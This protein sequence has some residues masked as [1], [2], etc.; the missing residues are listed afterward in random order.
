MAKAS[1][2]RRAS[3]L[4]ATDNWDQASQHE[5]S[6]TNSNA[7]KKAKTHE[8]HTDG[9]STCRSHLMNLNGLHFQVH[10]L[11]VVGLQ[12]QIK[13][14]GAKLHSCKTSNVSRLRLTPTPSRWISLLQTSLSIRWPPCPLRVPR[15]VVER[16]VMLSSGSALGLTGSRL[17]P[18]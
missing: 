5:G 7:R 10:L 3:S 18:P 17:V 9:R 6:V 12:G 14:V 15:E 4:R 11:K 2:K 16:Y 8:V 1:S 13:V